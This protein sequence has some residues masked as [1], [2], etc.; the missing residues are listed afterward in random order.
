[1]TQYGIDPT[2]KMRSLQLTPPETLCG[3]RMEPFTI[4][5]KMKVQPPPSTVSIQRGDK[6]IYFAVDNEG[7][8]CDWG[9]P[10]F[11]GSVGDIMW[12]KKHRK[13]MECE[14]LYYTKVIDIQGVLLDEVWMWSVVLQNTDSEMYV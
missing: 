12:I 9:Y 6:D 10:C 4:Y 7:K 2:A 13:A 3:H 8:P 1:M 14:S 5:R 11:I